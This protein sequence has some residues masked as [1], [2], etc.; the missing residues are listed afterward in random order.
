MLLKRLALAAAVFLPL[1][2]AHA[3]DVEAPSGT[4][5]LDTTHAS[6]LWRVDHLGLSKY[7]A[8][9]TR[10]DATLEF[11]AEDVTQSSLTVTVDPTSVE[12][13][14]EGDKDFDAFLQGAGWLNTSEFPEITFTSTR[15]ERTGDATGR[16]IGDLTF[17][18]TTLPM[19]LDI[20]LNAAMA[21]HPMLSQAALGFGATGTLMRSD[22]GFDSLLGP[23]GDEV[24][25]IVQAEFLEQQ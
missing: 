18:G 4:Y 16:V 13:D 6:L 19:T 8:R 25:I 1:S 24:E 20:E 23:I 7:T 10:F 12:T 17:L 22:F 2:A 9:F 15:V 3:A 14:F 21:K 5:T 11:D